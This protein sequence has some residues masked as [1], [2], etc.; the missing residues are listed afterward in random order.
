MYRLAQAEACAYNRIF[1]GAVSAIHV[2][3]RAP[4]PESHPNVFAL[5]QS[6]DELPDQTAEKM[7]HLFHERRDRT[8]TYL[9]SASASPLPDQPLFL[10]I[11]RS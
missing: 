9:I 5:W 7:R 3:L 4:I 6:C 11:S 2:A 1:A 8:W 10:A